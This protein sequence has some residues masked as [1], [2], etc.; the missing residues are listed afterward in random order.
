MLKNN[1]DTVIVG[2]LQLHLPLPLSMAATQDNIIF[3]QSAMR[4]HLLQC[5]KNGKLTMFPIQKNRRTSYKVKRIE[6]MKVYC[7]CRLP[8][9]SGIKW[10]QC[11]NC[12]EWFHIDK[13]VKVDQKFT[14]QSKLRWFCT[15]CS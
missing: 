4:D 1:Q 10:I 3:K 11:F 12:K 6:I 5:I 15:L 2:F 9:V 7:T 14:D 8:Q 13:C